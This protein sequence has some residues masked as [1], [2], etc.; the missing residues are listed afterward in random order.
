MD[1]EG[2]T[3]LMM[4]VKWCSFKNVEL[5]YIDINLLIKAGADVNIQDNVRCTALNAAS[6]AGNGKCFE[7]LFQ[8]GADVNTQDDEGC[9]SLMYASYNGRDDCVIKLLRFGAK[10]NCLKNDNCFNALDNVFEII[11]DKR[12]CCHVTLCSRKTSR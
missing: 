12:K 5:M 1:K 3:A 4:V 10:I 6:R 2:R 8:A 9:S 11:Q 7:T